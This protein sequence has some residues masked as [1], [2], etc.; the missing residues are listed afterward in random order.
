MVK[1][2]GEGHSSNSRSNYVTELPCKYAGGII[3]T[4]SVWS[5]EYYW[6]QIML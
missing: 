6:R 4:I 3:S 5:I 2:K 1:D